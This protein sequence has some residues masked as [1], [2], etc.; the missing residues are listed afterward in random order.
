MS[1][2]RLQILAKRGAFAYV[3]GLKK[4]TLRPHIHC[5]EGKQRKASFRYNI[6]HK[7]PNILDLVQCDVCGRMTTSTHGGGRYIV[8]P[9]LM[10][11][12][13]RFRPMDSKQKVKCF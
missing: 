13:I 3:K 8:L 9:L 12:P 11:T 7:T 1:E 10:T 5:F 2:T 4:T 6:P